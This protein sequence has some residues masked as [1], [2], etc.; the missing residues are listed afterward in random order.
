MEHG[1][2]KGTIYKE[3]MKTGTEGE[4]NNAQGWGKDLEQEQRTEM[5]AKEHKEHK[6]KK[7]ANC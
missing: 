5:A 4:N 1:C 2:R 3:A 6:D 7:G